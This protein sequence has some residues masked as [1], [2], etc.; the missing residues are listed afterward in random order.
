MENSFLYF[1]YGSSLNPAMVEFR[2]NERV[3]VVCKGELKHYSLGFN[4]KNPDGSARGNLVSNIDGFTLGLVYQI[5]KNRFEQLA[6]TE[7]EYHLKEFDIITE[8]GKV[9]AFAFICDYCHSGI[10]PNEKY[11]NGIIADAISHSFPEE[12]ILKI[13]KHLPNK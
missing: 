9:K 12:Y 4:R 13:K 5:N 7:P 2:I 3:E 1:G 6:Q 10:V 8:K 11:I